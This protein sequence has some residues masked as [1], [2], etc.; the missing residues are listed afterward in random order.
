MRRRRARRLE[1]RGVE[2][3]EQRAEIVHIASRRGPHVAEKQLP[4]VSPRL[5]NRHLQLA[6]RAR[7]GVGQRHDAST[8]R[9][10][11]GR[12]RGAESLA[13]ADLSLESGADLVFQFQRD[14]GRA[15]QH[16]RGRH[17]REDVDLRGVAGRGIEGRLHARRELSEGQRAE[18]RPADEQAGAALDR[19]AAR[20]VQTI[21]E[22]KPRR[23]RRA[24]PAQAP[25]ETDAQIELQTGVH[26]PQV[27][28]AEPA[29]QIVSLQRALDGPKSI[30]RTSRP[31][32]SSIWIG[33]CA[34][35]LVIS[36]WRRSVD[37]DRRVRA[38]R[39]HGRA[40][41]RDRQR[42]AH[43]RRV[44]RREPVLAPSRRSST[45]PRRCRLARSSV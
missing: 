25:I 21:A 1:Q 31:S 4:I 7:P 15:R 45:A 28:K 41:P 9:N 42:L 16:E 23:E 11:H 13:D 38:G 30:R 24:L 22:A 5:V 8:R 32:A 35:E 10:L 44:G 19:R 3:H 29:E 17:R 34:T 14:P 2:V 37:S 39:G 12:Q 40:I 33:W 26:V 6:I 43:A 36:R 20:L 27:P 18:R